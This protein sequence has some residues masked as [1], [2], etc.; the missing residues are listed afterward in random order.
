MRARTTVIMFPVAAPDNNLELISTKSDICSGQVDF[1][2]TR[3]VLSVWLNLSHFPFIL[4][5][6]IV[7]TID[8]LTYQ[9]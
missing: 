4:I 5:V 1:F 2:L 8:E 6:I 3:L 9:W 7:I